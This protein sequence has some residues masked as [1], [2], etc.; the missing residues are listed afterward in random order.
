LPW[1]VVSTYLPRYLAGMETG[2]VAF[3]AGLRGGARITVA[4]THFKLVLVL[5]TASRTHWTSQVLQICKLLRQRLAMPDRLCLSPVG[6]P[7]GSIDAALWP[8][9]Q[10][11][12]GDEL[13]SLNTIERS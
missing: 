10:W 1:C 7:L 6:F 12:S 8:D 2:A 3:R 5:P 9:R 11:G 13:Y 4:S